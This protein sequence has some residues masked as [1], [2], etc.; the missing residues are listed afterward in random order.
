MLKTKKKLLPI[1]SFIFILTA[2]FWLWFSPAETS[3]NADAD[4]PKHVSLREYQQFNIYTED[5]RREDMIDSKWG[6][7]LRF[8]DVLSDNV[9]KI[10][11]GI[12]TVNLLDLY[13]KNIF[14]N[15]MPL[16]FYD[17]AEICYYMEDYIW[18]YIPNLVFSVYRSI[19]VKQPFVFQDRTITPFVLYSSV[20]E[21]GFAYWSEQYIQNTK[22]VE[23]K[24]IT[25]NNK[26]YRY[27]NPK[28]GLLL[29]FDKNL[30]NVQSEFEGSLMK[31]NLVGHDAVK[32][33][34]LGEGKSVGENV[35]LYDAEG[36]AIAFKDITG[37]EITYH[38]E[39]FLWL[40][41]PNMMDYTKLEIK[42]HT[43]FLDSYLPS[44]VLYSN[45]KEWIDFDPNSSRKFTTGT[46][47]VSYEK[48]EWNNFDY[49][50]RNG[51]NGI[52]LKFDGYLSKLPNEID[53]GIK[54]VNKVKTGIGNRVKLD[55]TPLRDIN[56]AEIC[57][58]SQ[59]FLWIFIPEEYLLLSDGFPRLTIDENTEFLNAVLPAV[60]LY[61][62][63]TYWLEAEPEE[64]GNNAFIGIAYN[65]VP[66]ESKEGY[67]YTVLTFADAFLPP[68]EKDFTDGRRSGSRPNL[69]Q[70]GDAGQKIRINGIT[71]NE[72]YMLDNNTRLVF[73]EN[74]ALYML[75]R[76]SFLYSE[77]AVLP[78]LTIEN[79]TR[80]IDRTIGALTLYLVDGE[81]T[82]TYSSGTPLGED[83]DAPYIYYYGEDEFT[84][85]ADKDGVND[86]LSDLSV[87]LFDE[88][89]GELEFSVADNVYIP[90]GAVTGDKWNRGE[91]T[92]KIVATDSQN[93]AREK[94]ITINAIDSDKEFLSVYVNGIFS[95]RVR[96]GEKIDKTSDTTLAGGN[97]SKPDSRT[98]CFVF[99]GWTV[100]GKLW[101]FENDV[102]TEDVWFSASFGEYRRLLTLTVND[103]ETGNIDVS[104]VKYGDVIDFSEYKKDGYSVLA[105]IGEDVVKTVSVRDD[106]IVELQYVPVSENS[107]LTESVIIILICWAGSAVLATAGVMICKKIGKKAGEK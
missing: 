81:W 90:E 60:T 3:V 12:K 71:L 9:S 33:P 56:G 101:D 37:A 8:N 18:V 45:G 76:K 87:Y 62:D 10:N 73:G 79:G 92:I 4:E 31:T 50:N 72:M 53:G 27:F 58:Q 105:R 98:S 29:E 52:L 42:G 74:N 16:D 49:G 54:A 59:N 20:N 85:I 48:I 25:W 84:V 38:S 43:L 23:F 21:Y 77:P 1:L 11:G 15:D 19:S 46:V 75:F 30:S 83:T 89:D 36:N 80:F 2:V 95:Y 107:G 97:P 28:N 40:Y 86:F 103:P 5:S 93:N 57:Y 100:N 14:I 64:F 32:N 55:S 6:M 68:L 24:S 67:V 96:Y 17:H 99:T 22:T 70:T 91:W 34:F 63:G 82:K 106:L 65:N 7:L 51:K 47:N 61:F 78:T 104:T 69:A 94:E 102:A 44:V 39:R 13:G 41:V 26:G 66:E 88:R 35:F